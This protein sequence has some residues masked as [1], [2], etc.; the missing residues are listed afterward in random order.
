MAE[1]D[2][3]VVMLG[4]AIIFAG[5]ALLIWLLVNV[6]VCIFL[7]KLYNGVPA[8]HRRMAP[9]LVWL[10][11]IPLFGVIWNFIVFPKLSRSYQACFEASGDTSAGTCHSGLAWTYAILSACTYI[12]LF[13]IPVMAGPAALI[14]L[15]VYIVQMFELKKRVDASSLVL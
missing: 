6:V 1:Q 7:H 3:A 14:V 12:P 15:I 2:A 13:C 4:V 5:V 9:G 10:L 8:Q 11:L